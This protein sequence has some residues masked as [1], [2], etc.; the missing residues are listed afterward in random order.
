LKRKERNRRKNRA[1]L[2]QGE[3]F[4]IPAPNLEPAPGLIIRNEPIRRGAGSPH[5]VE[6]VYRS[7]GV[8]VYACRKYPGGVS[9]KEY[10]RL[11]AENPDRRFWGWQLMRRDME[12]FGRGKV[13]H[14]DHETITLNGWH[15]IL[16]NTEA[17][18]WF[19]SETL[20]FLD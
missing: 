12:V 7:G 1:T 3:W 17:D 18:A 6:E 4:F 20:V 5:F 2:R 10:N 14:R 8:T 16:V 19:M 11:L 13:T 9:E 15:Q